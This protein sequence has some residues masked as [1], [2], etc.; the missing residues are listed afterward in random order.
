MVFIV[1]LASSGISKLETVAC[2]TQSCFKEKGSIIRLDKNRKMISVLSRFESVI[3]CVIVG[4]GHIFER[5]QSAD[6]D[7]F[8]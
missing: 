5:L 8:F 6:T 3:Q 7:Q 1:R 4:R 2:L